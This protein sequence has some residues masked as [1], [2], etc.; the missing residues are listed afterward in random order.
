VICT[1]G[2][3]DYRYQC[4]PLIVPECSLD[5]FAFEFQNAE[6]TESRNLINCELKNINECCEVQILYQ[7]RTD[8]HKLTVAAR[9][10]HSGPVMYLS[11]IRVVGRRDSR[12][13][14]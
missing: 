12:R 4:I 5:R 10:K 9:T 1:F 2:T 11:V 7:N 13:K 14:Y 3:T 8:R 6:C